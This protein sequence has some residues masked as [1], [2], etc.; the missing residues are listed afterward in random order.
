[1]C[2]GSSRV[3]VGLPRI[4]VAGREYLGELRQ[5]PKACALATPTKY[6]QTVT[7]FKNSNLVVI[8]LIVVA[9]IVALT[10]FRDAVLKVTDFLK[11]LVP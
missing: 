5:P 6:D 9:V 8:C 3:N 2:V 1:M 4:T 11:G 7:R 10:A